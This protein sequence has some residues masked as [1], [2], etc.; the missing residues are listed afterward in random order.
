MHSRSSYRSN[1]SLGMLILSRSNVDKRVSRLSRRRRFQKFQ[2]LIFTAVEIYQST[3]ARSSG[4]P[5]VAAWRNFHIASER[6]QFGIFA[7][8]FIYFLSPLYPRENF[9]I[10]SYICKENYFIIRLKKTLTF[11]LFIHISLKKY[12]IRSLI[13]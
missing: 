4:S 13:A 9:P 1:S 10:K 5:S 11:N 12:H 2:Q 7:E 3:K 6:F 8:S